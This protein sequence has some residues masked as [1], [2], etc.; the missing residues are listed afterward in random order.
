MNR[1]DYEAFTAALLARLEPDPRVVGADGGRVD[2]GP[3]A[4]AG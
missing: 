2:G 4:H 1:H 3:V